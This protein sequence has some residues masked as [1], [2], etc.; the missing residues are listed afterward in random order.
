MV[1]SDKEKEYLLSLKP[2]DLT[3]SVLVDLFGDK[4][5]PSG[6]IKQVRRSR[7]ATTDEFT[8]YPKE[9]FV[10]E[11]TKTTV[12]RFIYNKYIIERVGLQDI[13]GYENGVIT[14]SYNGKIE[15][16]LSAALIADKMTIDQYVTYIDYR[17]NLGMQLN[18][19]ITTSFTMKTIKTPP[20]VRKKRDELFK[21]YDKELSEGDIVTSERIEKELVADAKKIL[22]NDPGMDLYNSEAR[23]NF[24]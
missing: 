4:L 19:V 18:S 14:D 11:P 6:D 2:E 12:G 23:G 7:F 1:I 15:G 22:G 13:L 9:Y 8:L 5:P 16:K 10:K 20:E 21:K 3:F 17:D 24:G